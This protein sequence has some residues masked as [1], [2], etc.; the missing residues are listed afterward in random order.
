METQYQ[1]S[2]FLFNSSENLTLNIVII[3]IIFIHCAEPSL[4]LN[5]APNFDGDFRKIAEKEATFNNRKIKLFLLYVFD[6]L[7][8]L[9]TNK[10]L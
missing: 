10:K 3:F 5:I 1:I 9:K 2:N 8:E 6:I 4:I 7:V